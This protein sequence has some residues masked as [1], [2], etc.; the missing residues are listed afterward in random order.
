MWI[1]SEVVCCGIHC[2][3]RRC[4]AWTNVSSWNLQKVGINVTCQMRDDV[5]SNEQVAND[6]MPHFYRKHCWYLLY[7]V[8]YGLS[9][10]QMEVSCSLDSITGKMGL[11]SKQNVVNHLGLILTQ[12]K[13]FRWLDMY[14]GLRCSMHL[15]CV[16]AIL[17]V[18][19]FRFSCME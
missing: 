5:R 17:C 2:Y 4:I 6:T 8:M 11:F 13:N 14:A 16:N 18:T 15:I 10:P 1:L 19:F 9:W 3:C 12:Y 7:T